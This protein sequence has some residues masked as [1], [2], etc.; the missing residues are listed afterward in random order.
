MARRRYSDEERANALAALA[1][2]GGNVEKTAR[3]LTI[4][5]TTL[6]QWANG[7]CHPEATQ[8]SERKKGPLSDHLETVAYALAGD[9]SDPER[10]KNAKFSEVAVAFGIVV[11]KM[12]VLRGQPSSISETLSDHERVARFRALVDEFRRENGAD[13][14]DS[15]SADTASIVVPFEGA[16]G[17]GQQDAG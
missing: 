7:H 15:I 1:A 12:Q 9:L 2:N 11:D 14:V 6:R 13:G 4:P 17:M 5:E 8:L 3:E 16:A 10:R